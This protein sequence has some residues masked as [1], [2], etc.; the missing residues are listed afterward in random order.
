VITNTTEYEMA[1]E[2]I[3]LLEERLSQLVQNHNPQEKGYTKAGIRKMIARIH[4][5]LALY[6]GGREAAPSGSKDASVTHLGPRSSQA[7]GPPRSSHP[8]RRG[9]EEVAFDG[10]AAVVGGVAGT[11]LNGTAI[12]AAAS[13]PSIGIGAKAGL[14][15]AA[16]CPPL[17]L[18]GGA[19]AIIWWVFHH[20]PERDTHATNKE[21]N[22]PQT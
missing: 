22:V 10:A 2:E 17:V 14:A 20:C 19:A 6:E 21:D 5:E 16:A 3:R 18:I 8:W 15:V 7:G 9:E 1:Q 4:E 12:G 11:A 13:R